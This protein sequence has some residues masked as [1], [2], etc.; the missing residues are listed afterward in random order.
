MDRPRR[1]QQESGSR[2]RR[3]LR[4]LPHDRRII[5]LAL[6]A[7]LPGVGVALLLLF[8]GDYPARVVW[9]V[10]G[11][12]LIVWLA[13]AFALRARVVRPL[14]TLANMLAALREGDFS[15]RA[16]L[17]Q[18]GA[19]DPLSLAYI[20]LNALEEILREQRLGAVEATELLR[21]VL[22]EVDLAIFAFDE[23]QRLRLVNRAGARL[24]GQP[25]ERLLDRTAD[26][27][28]LAEGLV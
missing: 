26:E 6:L 19:S 22:E 24:L 5:L 1:P 28:R 11:G 23:E 18:A 13:A 15:I 17:P 4:Q 3:G 21:K 9:T 20:E 12:L 7:G 10:T 2:R 16:R 8:L 27:L 25:A 14:Q